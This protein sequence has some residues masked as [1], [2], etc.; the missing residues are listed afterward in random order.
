VNSR[1]RVLAAVNGKACDW[2]PVMFWLNPHTTCRLLSEYQPGR[3]RLA[4]FMG[5]WAWQRFSRRGGME[6][7]AFSRAFPLVM[8]EYGNSEYVLDLGADIAVLSPDFISPSSFIGSIR[9][10]DGGM[11]VGGP[12]GGTMSL[13]GIYM[14]PLEPAV[15]DPRGLADFEFP[16]VAEKH[17][18]GV[19]QFRK[20]HPSICLLVEIGAMQQVLC[21]YILGMQ[22]FMLALVDYPREIRAFMERM[23]VWLE[24]IVWLAA[25]AGADMIF[26]QDDYGCN[27]RP[28]IS[29]DMWMEITFPQLSRLVEASHSR[30]LP[31]MLHSCGYQMPFLERYVQAGVDVLQSLQVGAGNDLVRALEIT[32]GELAFATGI[33]VQ[34]SAALTPSELEQSIQDAYRIGSAS[35]KFILGMTHMLQH[36][37][38]IEKYQMIFQTVHQFQE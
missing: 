20:N 36:D 34:R 4:S 15:T 10:R 17:F 18:H 21:D 24:N 2:V 12:F 22:V 13:A 7:D 31:F 1:E 5:K 8:E 29:M 27:G 35:G 38:P 32:R 9:F 37:L 16:D 23:A 33:D 30:G 14:H 3:S 25:D 19:R 11:T 6:A 28:L 26:L